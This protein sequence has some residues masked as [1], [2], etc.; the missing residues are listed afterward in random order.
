MRELVIPT[1]LQRSRVPEFF[2]QF[3]G[4]AALAHLAHKGRG[5]RYVLV[6][7]RAWYDKDDIVAW[8]ESN[9]RS[10]PA[11]EHKSQIEKSKQP[12]RPMRRRGRPTK[13]EQFLRD[14]LVTPGSSR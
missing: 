11:T 8:L 14:P 12:C 2:P 5:P 6:G 3:R 9:K 1:P 10:G 13:A 4:A 7:G